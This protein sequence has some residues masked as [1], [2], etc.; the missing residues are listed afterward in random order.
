[1]KFLFKPGHRL[2]CRS[3]QARPGI[4]DMNETTMFWRGT[5]Q[6][7]VE[8]A[9]PLTAALT[10]ELLALE[11]FTQAVNNA[12]EH[13]V[14]V[15]TRISMITAPGWYPSIPGW[16]GDYVPRGEN[17]QPDLAAVDPRVQHFMI[18]AS[19]VENP[20][21]ATEFLCD[22]VELQVDPDAVWKSV[23]QQLQTKENR[24]QRVQQ[25][26]WYQFS[27]DALHQATPATT[28][29]WRLFYRASILPVDHPNAQGPVNVIRR[30]TQIY[31]DVKTAGW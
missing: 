4:Q 16:H 10:Q 25:L 13:T 28:P 17:G 29:G 9:G 26:T 6:H 14:L 8:N 11:A 20:V 2:L 5:P 30:C 31:M 24:T 15:D 27:Q 21:S 23:N 19:T 1:M 3:R 12:G 18:L 22:R 7:L